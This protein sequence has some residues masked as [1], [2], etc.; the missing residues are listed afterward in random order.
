MN[1]VWKRFGL[2]AFSTMFFCPFLCRNVRQHVLLPHLLPR[3][4]LPTATLDPLATLNHR[5]GFHRPLE[6]ARILLPRT[7]VDARALRLLKLAQPSTCERALQIHRLRNQSAVA[8]CASYSTLAVR[9]ATRYC[10]RISDLRAT[11]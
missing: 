8:S 1:F 9:C 3:P 6:T 10:S 7:R 5:N 4:T 2:G 11:H